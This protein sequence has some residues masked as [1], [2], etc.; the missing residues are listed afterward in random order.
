ME[1]VVPP[2]VPKSEVGHVV[3]QKS[4]LPRPVVFSSSISRK[5]TWPRSHFLV[6]LLLTYYVTRKRC[7]PLHDDALETTAHGVP[8]VPVAP[9]PSW[10]VATFLYL[11]LL[12]PRLCPYPFVAVVRMVTIC[13]KGD[14]PRPS[15]RARPQVLPYTRK[16]SVGEAPRCCFG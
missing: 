13:H 5:S 1:A 8:Y 2:I 11:L 6:T 12:V 4:L 9:L 3:S 7:L 14:T 10:R 15:A 16:G